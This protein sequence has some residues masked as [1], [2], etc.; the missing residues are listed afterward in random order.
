MRATVLI[1]FLTLLTSWAMADEIDD[2]ATNLPDG[3][4]FGAMT[5]IPLSK[6]A[7]TEQLLKTCPHGWW[8]GDNHITNYIILKSKQVTIPAAHF[9]GARM[10]SYTAV[11]LKT[12]YGKKIVLFKYWDSLKGWS[13]RILSYP[14]DISGPI[15]GGDPIWNWFNFPARRDPR[16]HLGLVEIVKITDGHYTHDVSSNGKVSDDGGKTWYNLLSVWSG[17]ITVKVIES[18][19]IRTSATMTV[20]FVRSHYVHTYDESWTDW[21]VKPG[22]RLLVFFEQKDGKWS[23]DGFV[24]PIPY[25]LMPDYGKRLQA[26][27][28]TP[29]VDEKTLADR[30]RLYDE[31]SRR[32]QQQTTTNQPDMK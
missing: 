29:I 8:I 23:F 26:V 1:V 25:L 11:L 31:A 2:L 4:D 3:W 19:G 28:R 32:V 15:A 21:L 13:N 17:K 20:P 5:I 18:P 27:F 16:A 9:Q 6:S 7:S 12:A 14:E 10:N 22:A 24:D 30:K